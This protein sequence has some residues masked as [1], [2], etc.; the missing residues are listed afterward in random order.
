MAIFLP[1]IK[2]EEIKKNRF[3]HDF[4]E[5]SADQFPNSIAIRDN[6]KSYSYNDLQKFSN[7]ISNFLISNKCFPNDR[8]CILLEKNFHLYASILG[9][10]KSGACWVP[11]N[12]NF[13]ELRLVELIKSLKPKFIIISKKKLNLFLRVR[14]IY[15]FKIICFDA[16]KNK[17]NIFNQK[18]ISSFKSTKPNLENLSSEDLA[19]IIF[20]SGS[21][22]SPKG[23]MVT[24]ENTVNFL[25]ELS[26]KFKPKQY[27]N[28]AH[29]SEITFDPSIFDMFVCLK[30]IGTL[31][32]FNKKIYKID[33][34]KY[35]DE[36]KNINVIF[37]VPSL[38]NILDKKKYLNS[39][40][41]KELKHILLTGDKI[42]YNNYLK[43][44]KNL[45][46]P[47]FYNLYG[48][49][50]TAIISHWYQ[51]PK[52]I[53]K[54]KFIPVGKKLDNLDIKLIKNGKFS[55]F[56]ELFVSG[57]QVSKG[58]WDNEF[59]TDKYFVKIEVSPGLFR[60]YYRTGDILKKNSNK[61]Y[62]CG[63]LDNQVKIRG[64]RVELSEI[65]YAISEINNISEVVVI[66]ENKKKLKENL[67][68]VIKSN[69][70]KLDSR[71]IK[72]FLI[73]RLPS[74]MIPN[75]IY[76]TKK[77]FPLNSNGKIDRKKLSEFYS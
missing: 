13:P 70:R 2:M 3:Q 42:H 26:N 21:T 60:S 73:K 71:F 37:L 27:L 16:D 20:T 56:G 67:I 65:E 29:F 69:D 68:A 64:H 76:I 44:K 77:D 57:S 17:D 55:N 40:N 52:K 15:Y 18:K 43:W 32:P 38:L 41:L 6:G 62:Y 8:I 12:N 25:N 49:T 4:F 54:F 47:L 11:F 33:P 22:G 14:K 50:E 24:H 35:F 58:Y 39:N 36:N 75:N 10:L 1:G 23:V 31:V 9:I 72:K 74:Y 19:Y 53:K 5:K 48:T 63:R 66:F 51:F 46:D 34:S 7:K 45:K 30:N 28:Y 59:L 61:Y